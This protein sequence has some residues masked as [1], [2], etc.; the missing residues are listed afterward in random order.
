LQLD[1]RMTVA[2]QADY[3]IAQGCAVVFTS[4]SALTSTYALDQTTL[5]EIKSVANDSASALGLPLMADHFSYPDKSGTPR[6][7]TATEIQA[8]YMA[9]R[10]YFTLLSYYRVGQVGTLPSQPITIP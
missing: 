9:L 6:M 4:N 5:D 7:F 3:L 10:D 2:Q 8:L 1:L